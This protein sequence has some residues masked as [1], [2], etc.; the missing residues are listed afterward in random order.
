MYIALALS[1]SVLMLILFAIFNP[2]RAMMNILIL[3]AFV[4]G[5]FGWFGLIVVGVGTYANNY[6]LWAAVGTVAFV[7]LLVAKARAFA[8]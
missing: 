4:A 1:A 2:M 7:A 3:A 6:V 5:A 8:D